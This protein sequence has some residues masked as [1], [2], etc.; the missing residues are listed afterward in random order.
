MPKT[1]VWPDTV[2]AKHVV[3]LPDK[4]MTLQEMVTEGVRV[5][6]R[7][8]SG[9]HKA[10]YG[11]TP[12]SSTHGNTIIIVF[13]GGFEEVNS[14]IQTEGKNGAKASDNHVAVKSGAIVTGL[15][16]SGHSKAS[17][18]GGTVHLQLKVEA[19]TITVEHLS[20]QDV[21]G[22]YVLTGPEVTERQV[23]LKSH[24]GGDLLLTGHFKSSEDIIRLIDNF[25][26]GQTH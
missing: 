20:G 25:S 10:E 12:P 15:G 23:I 14:W 21:A 8:A 2:K 7:R 3:I 4:G 17:V 18:T 16:T 6:N 19:S 9:Q 26:I 5:Y 11:K 1:V 22:Q 13:Q 24:L